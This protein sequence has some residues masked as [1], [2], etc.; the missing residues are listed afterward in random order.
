MRFTLKQ[1]MA[2][3]KWCL[4]GMECENLGLFKSYNVV[5]KHFEIVITPLS[6]KL[7]EELYSLLTERTFKNEKPKSKKAG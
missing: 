5:T 6:L 4:A 1:I 7:L 2:F 3:N